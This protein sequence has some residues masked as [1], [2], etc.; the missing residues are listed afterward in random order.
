MTR[1]TL[2][3]G[4]AAALATRAA[5]RTDPP[6]GADSGMPQFT[7]GRR[8]ELYLSWTEPSGGGHAF[9]FAK[10]EGAKWSSAETIA[11]GANWFV[12][13]ADFASMT[14][15]PDGTMA[16]HWLTK[17]PGAGKFGYG[18][19][20]A[21]RAATGGPWKEFHGMS[22]GEPDDYAGFL[23][24][25]GT[26]AVYLAPPA[27]GGAGKHG[28]GHDH[29][30]TLR[31]LR[32]GGGGAPAGDTQI[33]ADVCS[34]CQTAIVETGNG[35]VA[36]YRDHREG[37]IRDISIIRTVG[38]AWTQPRPVHAD[39]WKINGCPT[40]GPSMIA[41]PGDR[42]AVAWMTR[43]S[44]RPRIQLAVSENAGESFAAPL[45]L[46][47][48]NPLGRPAL[49]QMDSGELLAVWLEKTKG[50]MA[51]VRLRRGAGR[52]VTVAAAPASRTTGFPKVAVH[53]GKV[54]VA[55][56]DGRVRTAVFEKGAV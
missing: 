45:R 55:W 42:I 37:E 38:G 22:L 3:T 14:V 16:A 53:G 20:L 17:A 47:D 48:G 39:G 25:C 33:D 35:L 46:D 24:F 5:G 30:K 10:W 2:W 44:D 1:R 6:A 21:R 8:G 52:S 23:S 7:H 11:A 12:N 51:A 13:W 56:R 31:F 40:E 19:R 15:L 28:D 34:C 54:L 26:G 18:I 43:A 41:G 9:R 29:R 32:L 50:T 36:A 27:E 49:A 4:A